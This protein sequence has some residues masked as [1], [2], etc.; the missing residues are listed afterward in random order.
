MFD[1]MKTMGAIAGLLKNKDKLREIG[2]E[3]QR[4]IERIQCIGS[5]GSG[6]VRVTVSGRFE[7]LEVQL[8]NAML[9]GMAADTS[10][11]AMAESLIREAANEAIQRAQAMIKEEVRRIMQE[12]DLPDIP[13]LDRMIGGG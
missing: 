13:G 2:E 6:A 5:A 1:Q 11:K 4:R 12:Y 8:D 7:V 3:L 10:G 9:H